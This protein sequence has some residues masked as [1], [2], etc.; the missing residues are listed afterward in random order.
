MLISIELVWNT[1]NDSK[2]VL[3]LGPPKHRKIVLNVLVG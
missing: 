3:I 2:V 1:K